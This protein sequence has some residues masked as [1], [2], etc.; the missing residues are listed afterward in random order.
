MWSI[1]YPPSLTTVNPDLVA[2]VRKA[3][4]DMFVSP[5]SGT[6]YFW[7]SSS[8]EYISPVLPLRVLVVCVSE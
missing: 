3:S 1:P 2:V 5:T 7:P 6:V 4:N 8:E